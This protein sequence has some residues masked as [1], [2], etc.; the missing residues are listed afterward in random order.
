MVL[1][2][3]GMKVDDVNQLAYIVALQIKIVYAI[4]HLAFV[5]IIIFCSLIDIVTY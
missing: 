3:F 5:G 2:R 1:G 4:V